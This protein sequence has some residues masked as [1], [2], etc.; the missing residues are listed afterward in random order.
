MAANRQLDHLMAFVFLA[1]FS[2]LGIMSLSFS[3]PARAVPA[4]TA[5]LGVALCTVFVVASKDS[6]SKGSQQQR[7]WRPIL[8]LLAVSALA[9]FLGMLL[10]VPA[11]FIL[12]LLPNGNRHWR[13]WGAAALATLLVYLTFGMILKVPLIRSLF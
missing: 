12:Y 8:T 5:A 3:A 7:P 10:L 11:T 13:A 1:T 6:G 2:L 4:F 9:S